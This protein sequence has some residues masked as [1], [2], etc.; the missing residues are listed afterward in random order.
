MKIPF[1]IESFRQLSEF[2]NKNID[3]PNI[4]DSLDMTL[5]QVTDFRNLQGVLDESQKGWDRF[6][7][8]PIKTINGL[9]R[10]TD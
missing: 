9:H 1:K 2:I 4:P 6:N 5:E 3:G 7:G 10:G 8:I